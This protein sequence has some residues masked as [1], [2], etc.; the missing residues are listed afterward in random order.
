M[1]PPDSITA[2][3]LAGGAARRLGGIDKGLQEY[4]GKPLIQ[5]AIEHV[6]PQVAQIIVSANRHLNRY[7]ALGYPVIPDLSW[8]ASGRSPTPAQPQHYAGP[9]AGIL[10][11]LAYCQTPW[12][13]SL[14]VDAPTLPPDLLTQ[15]WHGALQQNT[16]LAYAIMDDRSQYAAALVHKQLYPELVRIYQGGERR[17]HLAWSACNGKGVV[18]ASQ[19][20]F[21]N[22]N[23]WTDYER[24]FMEKRD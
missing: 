1:A 9:L 21:L 16:A 23:E 12:L 5:H 14:P 8:L 3:I 2:V 13:C 15:L 17:L 20:P 19:T 4:A 22:L 6:Q 18:I 11:A 10:S 7:S 24:P